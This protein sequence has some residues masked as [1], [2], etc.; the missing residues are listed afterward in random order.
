MVKGPFLTVKLPEESRLPYLMLR[1]ADKDYWECMAEKNVITE[2]RV[3]AKPGEIAVSKS[4]F[5]SNPRFVLGDSLTLPVGHRMVQGE[6]TDAGIRQ[7][8]ELFSET[9]EKNFTIVGKLDLTTQTTTPAIM[10][11][12]I[13]TGMNWTRRMN[14]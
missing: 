4:F 1:D 11:W 12:V 8:G 10:P 9:G 13:W 14:W 6:I 5:D 7:E 3:P 2:G